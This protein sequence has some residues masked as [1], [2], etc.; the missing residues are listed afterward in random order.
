MV[1]I[2]VPDITQ[3]ITEGYMS[4][5]RPRVLVVGGGTGPVRVVEGLRKHPLD[6]AAMVAMSDDGGSTGILRDELGALPP[7]DVQKCIAAFAESDLMRELMTYRFDCGNGLQGH[8][9]GNLI[10]AAL[11]K[12][13]GSFDGAVSAASQILRINGLV[14]P[15]TLDK[16]TLVAHIGG[17]IVRGESAIHDTDFGGWFKS[18]WLDPQ[19]RANPKALQAIHTADI[20]VIGPG[21]F[22][23][24]II[25]NMLPEG[26]VEAMCASRARKVLVCNLMSYDKHTPN[27]SVADFTTIIQGYLRG[28]VDT[29]IYNNQEPDGQLVERYAREGER[30]TRWD[31]LPIGV[32]LVGTNLIDPSVPKALQGDPIKRTLIRHDPNALA[33]AIYQLTVG[34]V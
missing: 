9:M 15:V 10:L 19:A 28:C 17:R 2:V 29:V 16:V 8:T 27:F 4:Q 11:E 23:S 31:E 7:G 21:D 5:W 6:L 12:I 32:Q 30:L 14:I 18:M 24:S 13:T 1:V 26:I 3:K 33:D 22:Y 25:P 20:I 34:T